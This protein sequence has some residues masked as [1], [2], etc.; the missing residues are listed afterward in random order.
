MMMMVHQ[1]IR[2][3]ELRCG[4]LGMIGVGREIKNGTGGGDGAEDAQPYVRFCKDATRHD[5]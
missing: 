3:V 5:R 1:W 4:Y 2:V